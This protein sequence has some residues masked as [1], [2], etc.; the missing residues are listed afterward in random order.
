MNIKLKK[1]PKEAVCDVALS[2]P[3]TIEELL[4]NYQKELPYTILAARVDNEIKELTYV[5]EKDCAVEFLDMRTQAANLIYQYSLC[6]IYLKAID[7]VL[8][9]VQVEIQNSLNKGLHTEIM[10]PVTEE[11]VEEIQKRMEE[12][13]AQDKPIVKEIVSREQAFK[14]LAQQNHVERI[15]ILEA[16]PEVEHPVFY[17]LEG[18][19]NFFYGSM[20]PSTGYIRHFELVKYRSGVILRFPYPSDPE[21]IPDYVDEKK[22]CSAFAEAKKWHRLM[23][24]SYL[25]DLNK[26]IKEDRYKELVLLSEALQEKKVVEI[27]NQITQGKKRIVLIAG[28]SSSGKTTFARRLCIQLQ[29]NGLKPLYMGTDDYFVERSETPL[30]ADGEPNFEDLEAI[31]IKLFNENMNDLLA[32]REVDL[33]TFDFIE[34]VK[35]YG[36]RILSI[37][38]DELLV[39]EGIHALNRKLTEEIPEEEKFRIYISPFTQLNMDSHN[40]IPTTDARMLRRMVRDHLYRGHSAQAT[41][42]SWPK[43][44]KGEDKNIFP[45]NGEADVL[46]NSALTYELALLKKHAAP[47]LEE[48]KQSEPEYSDARRLLNFLNFFEVI[49]DETI[50]PNNSILREFIGGSIFAEDL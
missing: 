11:Q 14:L 24:V 38:P 47:L 13:V 46:F 41:I 20:V 44:R 27:A 7:D 48:I 15:R 40:R 17:N 45:F 23:E 25:A 21:K 22:L 49:E 32:G 12:L 36:K 35:R 50:I 2:Q 18:Y 39:I 29:V 8:G 42:A 4:S 3:I 9:Q 31:D 10:A 26:K 43:V 33:P 34:G 30:D 6:L 28:P 19:Q 37:K 1:G 5:L 16:H